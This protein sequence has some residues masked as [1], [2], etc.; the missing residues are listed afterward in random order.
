VFSRKSENLSISAPASIFHFLTP[1]EG[2]V[3]LPFWVVLSSEGHIALGVRLFTGL[4]PS[5]PQPLSSAVFLSSDRPRD[6]V[7]AAV[8][9]RFLDMKQTAVFRCLP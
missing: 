5:R 2:L 3:A 1:R 8:E 7:L 9:S 6:P 4:Q